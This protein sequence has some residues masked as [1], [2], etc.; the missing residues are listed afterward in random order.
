[1][2]ATALVALLEAEPIVALAG[3]GYGCRDPDDNALIETA[4]RGGAQYLVTGDRDLIDANVAAPLNAHG[5]LLITAR[6]FVAELKR[7]RP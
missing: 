4:I 1:V 2:A 7:R 6:A 3:V 5:V